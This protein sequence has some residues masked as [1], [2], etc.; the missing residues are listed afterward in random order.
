MPNR[1]LLFAWMEKDEEHIWAW[2]GNLVQQS[3][4]R[5]MRMWRNGQGCYLMR[6]NAQHIW[7][8]FMRL[9]WKIIRK[10]IAPSNSGPALHKSMQVTRCKLHF[11]LFCT[12]ISSKPSS[13]TLHC[14]S[15]DFEAKPYY[16]YSSVHLKW[17]MEVLDWSHISA[18]SISA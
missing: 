9:A 16:H 17:L 12:G 8:Q 13:S 3:T 4:A 11:W 14:L 5:L 7:A 15:Q 18:S 1:L 10:W 6:R 2:C